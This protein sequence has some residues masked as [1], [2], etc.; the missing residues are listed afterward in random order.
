[1]NTYE[2]VFNLAVPDYIEDYQCLPNF[3]IY[4]EQAWGG[5]VTIKIVSTF[6]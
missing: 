2:T 3:Q 1:L 4:W 6:K 5:V